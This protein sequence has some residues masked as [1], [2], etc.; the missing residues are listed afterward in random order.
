MIRLSQRTQQIIEVSLVTASTFVLLF[1]LRAAEQTS[2]SLMWATAAKTG[3]GLFHPH[4]LIYNAVVH[5]FLRALCKTGL[6]C[7]AIFAAQLHNIMWAIVAS[8]SVYFIV[9]HIL[10]SSLVGVLAA[11]SLDVML[12]FWVFSTEAEVYVPATACLAG[13]V[14]VLI[15]RPKGNLSV[16]R[17]AG[18]TLFLAT[19]VLYQQTNVLFCIPL[20]WY[21]FAT[22]GR[23]RLN[24]TIAVLSLAGIIVLSAY[25]LAFLSVTTGRTIGEFITYC[26]AYLHVRFP[27]TA[28][29]AHFGV[30]GVGRLLHS[31]LWDIVGPSAFGS[32]PVFSYAELAIF[33]LLIAALLLWN[34]WQAA[35][36]PAHSEIRILMLIWLV[37][38][39]VFFLWWEPQERDSFIITLIPILVLTFITLKDVC[40]RVVHSDHGRKIAIAVIAVLAVVIVS[41]VNFQ[42]VLPTHRSKGP[43]YTEASDLARLAPQGCLAIS[44]CALPLT[45]YFGWEGGRNVDVEPVLYRF[46]RDE[47]FGELPNLEDNC[48]IIAWSWL[49]PELKIWSRNGYICPSGWLDFAEWLFGFEYDSQHSLV[50][51]RQ[52]D[53]VGGDQSTYIVI[54]PTRTEM[55][56]LA[57]LFQILD[58]KI[59]QSSGKQVNDL[60]TWFSTAYSGDLSLE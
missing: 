12:G 19:S 20:G 59:S 45:Y 57:Q 16:A 37:P 18:I 13:L 22:Q 9:K 53:V 35:K 34:I 43:S 10:S 30:V 49:T 29:F 3:Q 14:A 46:Y 41:A 8:L 25:V 23:Q 26:T 6:S 2:D 31:Q 56:G 15:A 38:Y 4:S 40:H 60:E 11:L 58:H 32:M 55:N 36:D 48:A 54:S 39:Y 47:T 5:L 42:A 1:T 52:F 50:S 51:C 7:D 17:V 21:L 28:T 27:N 24:T 33:A 44:R